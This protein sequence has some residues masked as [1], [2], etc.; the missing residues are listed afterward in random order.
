MENTTTKTCRKCKENK[1]TKLFSKD[2]INS[3]GYKNSCKICIKSLRKPRK[4]IT[5]PKQRIEYLSEEYKARRKVSQ[6]KYREQNKNKIQKTI[7][8]CRRNKAKK[9]PL[10]RFNNALK[11][12]I[13][14]AFKN[15]KLIKCTKTAEILGCSYSDFKI[16]IESKF[17]SWMTWENRGLYN[18]QLNYGWDL[19]HIIPISSAKTI[20]DVIKL[21]HFTNFQPLC[22]KVNRDIKRNL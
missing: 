15:K 2:K 19:D 22:S 7:N 21:N 12:S 17:E 9:D 20:D 3:D 8:K 14:N 10:A 4:K 5:I 16:Y 13:K 11:L 6:K 1:D 18:G